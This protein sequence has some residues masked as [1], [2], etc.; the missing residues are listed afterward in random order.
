MQRQ[1]SAGEIWRQPIAPAFQDLRV[2]VEQGEV[3]DVPNVAPHPQ[4]LRAEMIEA[5]EVD[6]GEE[7]AGQIADRQPAPPAIRLEQVVA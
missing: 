7:L 2:I 6:V 4:H 3:V 5:I 1:A